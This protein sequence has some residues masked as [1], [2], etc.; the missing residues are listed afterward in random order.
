MAGCD[1]NGCI[2]PTVSATEEENTTTAVSY[3]VP[4][5]CDLVMELFLAEFEGNAARMRGLRSDD[6]L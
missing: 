3:A 6:R 4:K 5:F 2:N 1:D